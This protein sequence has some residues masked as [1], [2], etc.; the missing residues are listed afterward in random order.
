MKILIL[1]STG[2][3]GKTLQ[4]YL[5]KKNIDFLTL[6]RE[7][8]KNR[9]INLKNFSNFKKLEQIISKIK[10]THIINCIGVTKFNNT[11][12]N[13]KLTIS[14]NTKMPIYLAKLCKLNKIYL[15][16]ISTDCVFSG[17]KGNYSDNSVKDS[18]DLYGLSKNK[19]E[20]KNKFT[21]TI[22]TSF[23][24]P[25]LNTKKSLLSWFLNE[26]KFVRGYSKAFFSGLTSLELC[27]IIDNYFI[28]KNILQNKII[29]I[30]SRRISKFILLTKIRMIFKKKID[31][32]RYQNFII[33]RSLDSKKFRKLSNYKVVKWDKMLLELKK[34]MI[35]NNYKF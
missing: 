20:V 17:K 27:K 35:N 16:H 4:L 12:K 31:I 25:E 2:V 3:L 8:S 18:K 5:S 24:G 10:P 26:K 28:K 21:S 9:N 23:I 30:G 14:L 19:G 33:D 32:V 1:G 29:N 11:Y 6:S 22:R 13:K 34:F 7:K 15:L